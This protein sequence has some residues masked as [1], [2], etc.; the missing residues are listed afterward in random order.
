VNGFFAGTG[1]S[2]AGLVYQIGTIS[3]LTGGTSNLTGAAALG[4]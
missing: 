2:H 4:R 3:L 1:A